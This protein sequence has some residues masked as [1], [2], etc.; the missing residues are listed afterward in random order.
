LADTQNLSKYRLYPSSH[1]QNL[2]NKG[3]LVC[4]FPKADTV[5]LSINLPNQNGTTTRVVLNADTSLFLKHG[6]YDVILGYVKFPVKIENNKDT[7]LVLGY[8]TNPSDNIQEFRVYEPPTT[9]SIHPHK[10]MAVP[11]GYYYFVNHVGGK[12][13]LELFKVTES[14]VFQ[15]EN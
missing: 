1:K 13:I 10:T 4:K 6:S 9:H 12:E 3:R 5:I 7:H 14:E 2:P 15:Y 11:I 8:L